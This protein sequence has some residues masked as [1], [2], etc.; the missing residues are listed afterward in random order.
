MMVTLKLQRLKQSM[1]RLNY[2]TESSKLK[3][4]FI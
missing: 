2:L 3:D 1:L 4:N